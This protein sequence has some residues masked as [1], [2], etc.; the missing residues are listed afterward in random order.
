M[1]RLC[2]EGLSKESFSKAQSV[3]ASIL[4][5]SQSDL[6]DLLDLEDEEVRNDFAYPVFIQVKS[7]AENWRLEIICNLKGTIF[8]FSYLIQIKFS[9]LTTILTNVSYQ[10]PNIL[11][12]QIS[13]LCWGGPIKALTSPLHNPWA[14]MFS[15]K[16]RPGSRP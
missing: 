11:T 14:A 15:L 1:K 16:F 5:I 4:N 12:V 7:Q 3:A 8:L 10:I 9:L 2:H 6:E 13:R